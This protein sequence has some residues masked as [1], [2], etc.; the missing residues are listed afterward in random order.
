ML[1]LAEPRSE[2]SAADEDS[3]V[4]Q[5]TEGDEADSTLDGRGQVGTNKLTT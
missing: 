1:R 4:L 5:C 3:V 2:I